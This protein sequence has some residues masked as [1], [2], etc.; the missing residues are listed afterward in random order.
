VS[1][2]LIWLQMRG[3]P[4]ARQRARAWFGARVYTGVNE[5]TFRRVV[6]VLLFGS[7]TILVVRGL[8]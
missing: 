5:A 8:A 4:S 1:L 6:L 2:P 3:G 7:G